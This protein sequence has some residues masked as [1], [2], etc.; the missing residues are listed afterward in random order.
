MMATSRWWQGHVWGLHTSIPGS[1]ENSRDSGKYIS[2]LLSE[3]GEYLFTQSPTLCWNFLSSSN[4]LGRSDSIPNIS[5]H[6][7]WTQSVMTEYHQILTKT[8]ITSWF[9]ITRGHRFLLNI[10]NGSQ[11]P[12]AFCRANNH[13]WAVDG[14]FAFSSQRT[15][16]ESNSRREKSFQHSLIRKWAPRGRASTPYT[17]AWC[18]WKIVDFYSVLVEWRSFIW[19]PWPPNFRL[20]F[21]VHFPALNSRL[22]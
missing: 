7:T 12:K 16:F 11:L 4:Y 9:W 21:Q 6:N 5:N 8:V 20:P 14:A 3:S 10:S 22:Y 2:S 17:L 13:L 15:K 1:G 18:L 19:G